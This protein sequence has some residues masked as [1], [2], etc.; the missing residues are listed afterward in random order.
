[1][2]HSQI[3]TPG[4]Q[5]APSIKPYSTSE[6]QSVKINYQNMDRPVT[7]LTSSIDEYHSSPGPNESR[8]S[9]ISNEILMEPNQ[10]E[11]TVIEQIAETDEDSKSVI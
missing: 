2:P 4:N 3:I 10:P 6:E 7:T 8:R 9:R 11:I 5:V 1:M